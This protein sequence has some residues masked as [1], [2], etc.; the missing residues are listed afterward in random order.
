MDRPN[1]FETFSAYRNLLFSIAYRMLGSAMDAEDMVQE[2]YLNWERVTT[3]EIESP[4]SYLTAIV[5]RLCIDHLRSA[6][7]RREEYMG[8]WLPEP[9]LTDPPPDTVALAESL[10]VAF[11]VM[12]ESLSPI[13]RAVFLLREV[14]EYD[15]DEVARIVDKSEVNCRQMVKRAKEHITTRRPRFE[16]SVEQHQKMLLKFGEVCMTGDMEGLLALLAD[17]I[18]EYS[19]G[20][21]KVS[22]AIHPIKGASN[23]AHF[24]ISIIT[25]KLPPDYSV[26]ML[27]VNGQPAVVNYSGEK[28]HSVILLDIVDGRI[29]T[30]YYILNPDKLKLIPPLHS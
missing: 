16:T 4:K 23:V 3:Q 25:K 11:L 27:M 10:S 26:Q 1:H 15:Y 29:Q 5:T 21:R 2:S 7:V 18:V 8:P 28:P 6:K 13:E 12:L 30:I 14:F 17:D 19:D 9:I 20:G 22:A 24:F